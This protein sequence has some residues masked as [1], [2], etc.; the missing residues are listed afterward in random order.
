MTSLSI[1]PH[2]ANTIGRPHR[3]EIGDGLHTEGRKSVL[4]VSYRC[5]LFQCIVI[6][7]TGLWFVHDLLVG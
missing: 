7:C 5:E 4:E 1:C 6:G 2:E 3:G